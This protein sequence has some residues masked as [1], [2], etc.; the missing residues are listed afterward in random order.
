MTQP[1]SPLGFGDFLIAL[2]ESIPIE[3]ARLDSDY[4][5]RLRSFIPVLETAKANGYEGLARELVPCRIIMDQA[6][7]QATFRLTVA[8]SREFSLTARPL[9]VAYTRRYEYSDLTRSKAWATVRRAPM[10]PGA[11]DATKTDE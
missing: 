11:I 8:Q 10:Q 6:E 7:I 9:N 2:I 4:D 3:Q 5:A 1:V